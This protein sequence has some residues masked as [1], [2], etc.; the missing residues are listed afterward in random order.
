MNQE[1][2]ALFQQDQEER[3]EGT[4]T[5]ESDR[6]RRERVTELLEAGAL[7][8]AA[9]YFH[10]AVIFQHGEEAED[11]RR[12]YELS[13]RAAE[14]GHEKGRRMAANAYDRWLLAQGKP[15]K[16]GTQ[17]ICDERGCRLMELAPSTTDEERA[18]WDVPPLAVIQAQIAEMNRR[19][20]AASEA[21]GR[22]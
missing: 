6:R 20:S 11:Y 9:D 8:D 3:R 10:A 1:V 4:Y 19:R 22:E 5:A 13:L 7:Q 14:L 16:Y 21:N 12:A 17:I 18:A 15:Q 2:A